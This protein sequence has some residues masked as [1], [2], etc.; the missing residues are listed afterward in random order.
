MASYMSFTSSQPLEGLEFEAKAFLFDC[1][2]TL[3]DTMG[4]HHRSWECVLQSAGASGPLDFDRFHALGGMSGREVAHVLC[5]WHGLQVDVEDLVR[6]KRAS[7]L[8]SASGC[9]PIALTASFARKVAGT[10]AVAV[11]SGGHRAAVE[12]VLQAAGLRELFGVVVTPEDVSRGKPAP[13]MF[14]L[15]A[16]RLG[17][18]PEDCVVFEDGV[19][20]IEAARAAGMR[21]VVIEPL[22]ALN[23]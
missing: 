14:L 15:A 17:V 20:G 4:A 19:P 12:T 13:D 10:H 8:A 5:D 23:G 2:G 9:A 22:P 18:A 3:V 6:R 21:V 11:V 16:E 7:F 1:D